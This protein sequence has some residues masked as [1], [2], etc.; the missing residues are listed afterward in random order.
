MFEIQLINSVRTWEKR[1]E[2]EGHQRDTIPH[3]LSQPADN[4][5]STRENPARAQ[6]QKIFHTSLINAVQIWERRWQAEEDQRNQRV[7]VAESGHETI[8]RRLPRL[9]LG[10]DKELKETTEFRSCCQAQMDYE[11]CL[12]S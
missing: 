2:V 11:D 10:R 8:F 12:H 6:D 4:H 7:R 1:I 3:R 5:S 9:K